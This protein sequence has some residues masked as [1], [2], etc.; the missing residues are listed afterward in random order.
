ME[1][2]PARELYA[3]VDRSSPEVALFLTEQYSASDFKDHILEPVL[4]QDVH[5]EGK[6]DRPYWLSSMQLYTRRNRSA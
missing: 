3:L 6:A 4:A 2:D 1:L 5:G